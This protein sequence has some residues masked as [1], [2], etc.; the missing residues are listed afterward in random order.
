MGVYLPDKLG[1]GLL[2][3][4]TIL[5]QGG[6]AQ[7]SRTPSVTLGKMRGW[8]LSVIVAGDKA[9]EVSSIMVTEGFN[10]R[11]KSLCLLLKSMGTTADFLVDPCSVFILSL[12]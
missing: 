11:Q 1:E 8:E 9:G 4:G 10:I 2:D 6:G 5:H 3:F 12:G 7:P